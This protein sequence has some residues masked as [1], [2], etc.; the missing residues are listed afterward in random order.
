MGTVEWQHATTRSTMKNASLIPI[1]NGHQRFPEDPHAPKQKTPDMEFHHPHGHVHQTKK[2]KEYLFQFFMLFLAV[3]CG[4]L[5]E[6]MLEHRIENDRER[7]FVQ[8]FYEDLNA[9]EKDFLMVAKQLD[10]YIV[11]ADSLQTLLGNIKPGQPANA[12]YMF[13]REIVRS[14]QTNLYPNDRTMVQLRN[15]GGMRL[16]QNK[17]VSDSMVGYYRTIDIIQFMIDDAQFTKRSLRELYMPLLNA[18]D[19]AKI[20]GG[21]S[22][23]VSIQEPIYL[24]KVDDDR[25]NECLIEVNRIA[26]LNRTLSV[27]IQRL[28]EKARNIK[29]FIK[30][31]YQLD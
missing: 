20:V 1:T 23:I 8:S 4:F 12:I 25:I 21:T 7:Q 26:T 19:F 14:S 3:F 31:A 15:A 29:A 13:L 9:D 6:Y 11:K 16:I 30:Q 2:W 22:Q 17:S 10:D 5:A 28:S 24:R 18:T 27:R